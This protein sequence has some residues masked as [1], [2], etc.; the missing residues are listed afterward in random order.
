M[1][2][3]PEATEASA[4]IPYQ[5]V[6]LTAGFAGPDDDATEVGAWLLAGT[7]ANVTLG[8]FPLF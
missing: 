5:T 4:H 7:P 3:V 2:Y 1:V 8:V 6:V